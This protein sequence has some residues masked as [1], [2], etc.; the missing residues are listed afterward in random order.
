MSH[1]IYKFTDA[2]K[3][4]SAYVTYV[5]R[6]ISANVKNGYYL[7]LFEEEGK[8]F[9]DKSTYPDLHHAKRL[10]KKEINQLAFD[11]RIE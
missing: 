4:F 5:D 11:R 3:R 6:R 1:G 8:G 7:A 2:T 10:A 9:I